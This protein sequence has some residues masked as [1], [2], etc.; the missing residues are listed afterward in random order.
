MRTLVLVLTA[1]AIT[2][3]AAWTFFGGGFS[4]SAPIAPS[5][6]QI[7][8]ADLAT[9][10]DADLAAIYD[11]SCRAC[12]GVEGVGAPLTGHAAEWDRRAGDRGGLEALVISASDGFEDMPAMGLCNDC[13]DQQLEQ[14]IVFMMKGHDQ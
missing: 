14:L 4:T 11:R 3:I 10:E 2:A 12:H 8:Y 9:P 6:E 5:A 7:D 13:S 1:I